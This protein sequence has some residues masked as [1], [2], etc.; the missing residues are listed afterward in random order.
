MSKG[1][2]LAIGSNATRI[3]MQFG[4]W[5]RTRNYLNETVGPITSLIDAGYEV[6]LATPNGSKPHMDDASN[7]AGHFGGDHFGNSNLFSLTTR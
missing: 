1:T 4:R 6:L 3:E 5:G 2:V 7:S